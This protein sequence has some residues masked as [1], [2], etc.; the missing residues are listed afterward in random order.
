LKKIDKLITQSFI[1]PA[2]LS[3]FIATFVLV[4]QFLWKYID[5][6]LG[7]GITVFEIIELIFYYAVTLIPMAVPI[8]VL[9]S[10]VMVFGDMAEKY[11]LSSMKSAGVSLLRIMIP[12]LA[13]ASLIALFSIFASNYL[14]PVSLLQFNKRFQ[15]IRKQKAALAIEQGIFNDAFGETIIRVNKIDDDKRGIHDVLIFDHTANDKSLIGI[16]SAKN[17]EMYTADDGRYFVMQL[18]TGVHYKEGEK[19]LKLGSDQSEIPFTRT[20]FDQWIKSFDMNQFDGQDGLLNFNRNREDMMNSIQLL[21]SIDS[22]R[23]DVKVNTEK[24][25]NRANLIF[26][27]NANQNTDQNPAQDS[28]GEFKASQSD[29]GYQTHMN[30]IKAEQSTLNQSTNYKKYI[31]ERSATE[32]IPQT[33]TDT[34]PAAEPEKKIV[35]FKSG[36]QK[37]IVHIADMIDSID[38]REVLIRAQTNLSR[39][40]DELLTLNNINTDNKRYFEKYMLRLNQQYSW[41]SV[42]IIFLFIGAPLGSIIRKG[43]YGYPLLVA[44]LFYMIF[45]I[46]TIY[47]EKLNK[48]GDISGLRAAW[49][50]CFILL[51]FAVLLSY[52][53]LRDMGLNFSAFNDIVGKY[54]KRKKLN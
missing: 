11:E 7:K 45:I 8:T 36:N 32:Q 27:P 38:H 9:I 37:G 40:R 3:Y 17:G 5:D 21:K 1:G 13:V 10:S 30:K 53:A 14:K 47:G 15:T 35:S 25:A 54:F 52:M 20:Y 16:M 24:I 46:S 50:S 44:I 4:M 31:S 34:L 6:I 23:N 49:L 22:F 33:T 48:N 41:A 28:K 18:D 12:G 19:K 39:D 42:C 2:I 51:P 43:G 29:T 26:T